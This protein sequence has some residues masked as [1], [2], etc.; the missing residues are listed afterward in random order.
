M[1]IEGDNPKTETIDWNARLRSEL[2]GELTEEVARKSLGRFFMTNIGILIHQLTG[3]YME[4][5][6]RIVIKGWLKSNFSLAVAGRSLGKSMMASHFAY[7]YCLLNP[8]HH[9]LVVSATFRSSRKVVENIDQWSRKKTVTAEGKLPDKGGEMLLEC[10]DGAMTK[11]ADLYRIKFRNGSTVTAVPLGDPDNLRGFR[12]NALVIDEGLL[13][14][15]NTINFVLK[16]FLAGGSDS[17]KKQGIRRREKRHIKEGKMREEDRLVFAPSSKMIVL[18]S[19]SYKWE[20]LYDMYKT[21]MKIIT[22]SDDKVVAE[23]TAK[24]LSSYFVAQ[25]S[26]KIVNRDLMD[27]GILEEIEEKRIPES[28]IRREYEA[29]FTEESDGYF[30]AKKM[31]FCTIPPGQMPCI[32]IV[33]E[34]GAEYVLG[35]DPNVGEGEA[36]DHFAMSLLKIVTNEKGEKCGLLVHSYACSGAGTGHHIAYLH[37]LL[38]RFN[39]VY[40]ASDAS[41]GANMD[42]INTCN[43]SELFKREKLELNPIDAEFSKEDFETMMKSVKK[44]YNPDKTVRRIVQKQ[45]FNS[46]FLR[47]ANEYLQASFDRKTILFA[48]GARSVPNAVARMSNCNILDIHRK[49]PEFYEIE[50]SGNMDDF[51]TI[52]DGLIDLTKKECALIEMSSTSLGNLSYDLPHHMTR[53]RKNPNRVRRDSYSSLLLASWGFKIYL[54]SKELVEEKVEEWMPMMIGRR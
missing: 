52:Q 27:A 54:G 19:A 30:S 23:Q 33:G 1:W 31:G 48:S 9:V 42:F 34:K 36:T 12:C 8:N 13:I 4:P 21:Y 49:H 46:H 37:Y 11:K 28:I 47:A 3:F 41:Q 53:N 25:L 24:G 29:Q 43:E 35:I 18:S 32:E 17:T 51:I 40:I 26:Y 20:E 38:E 44:S 10:I 22:K 6:Q 7:L 14:S 50:G 15:Q 16:P 39:I 45:A 2:K 5:Y